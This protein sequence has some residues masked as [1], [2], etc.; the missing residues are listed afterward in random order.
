MTSAG[1]VP[2]GQVDDGL[3]RSDA[4]APFGVRLDP[5]RVERA[6]TDAWQPGSVVLV[7]GSDL[8]RADIQ[9]AV[10]VRRAGGED[11]R[12]RARGHRPHR[13]PAARPRRRRPTWS[14]SSDRP[15]R[16]TATSLSVAAVR[17]PGFAPGLLR[18]TTT[19]RD[20]FVNLTDVAPTVLTYFGLD[21]PDAMEG[22]RME[23]GDGGR[24]AGR[25][26]DVPRERERGRPL[27][28]RPGRA[29]D[30]RRA[31]ASRCCSRSP[32]SS[33]DRWTR[34]PCAVGDRAARVRR[35]VAARVPR[36][37]VPRG[38]VP[39]RS[40]RRC[41]RVLVVRRGRAAR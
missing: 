19:Q 41:V 7:E 21:R 18:S 3:L 30:E 20:G 15:R 5:D 33:L 13:R 10:R 1:K 25:A 38:P 34:A 22:R 27:P 35:A 26:P 14:W 37:H 32:P 17:G 40:Q 23:T 31:R 4:A 6:F 11:A 28:R 36:R 2:G 8:V 9:V 29:V 39:L 12:P 16:R 24:V